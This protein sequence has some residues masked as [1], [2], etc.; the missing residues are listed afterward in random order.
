[1]KVVVL[2]GHHI[3]ERDFT[4]RVCRGYEKRFCPNEDILKI[5]PLNSI[6]ARDEKNEPTIDKDI[7]DIIIQYQPKVLIDLHHVDGFTEEGSFKGYVPIYQP[8]HIDFSKP[9][10]ILYDEGIHNVTKEKKLFI[11]FLKKQKDISEL[12]YCW[13]KL[14]KR[15]D[16]RKFPIVLQIES[17]LYGKNFNFPDNEINRNSFEKTIGFLHKI[18]EYAKAHEFE[19]KFPAVDWLQSKFYL[20]EDRFK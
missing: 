6:H 1:M 16:K 2:Y 7:S 9:V 8:T 14:N 3:E 11:E 20:L 17:L 15:W 18:E 19:S 4:E 12:K 5:I 10:W 13:Y